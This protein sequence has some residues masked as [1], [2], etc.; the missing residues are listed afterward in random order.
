VHPFRAEGFGL[1]IV[2]AMG[3]GLPVI[4]TGYGPTLD[5]CTPETA[6]LIPARVVLLGEELPGDLATVAPPF[7]AAPNID[8]LRHYLRYVVEHRDEARA[9]GDMAR[10]WVLQHVTDG[11][12]RIEERLRELCKRPIR[13]FHRTL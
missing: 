8:L 11:A 2:E 10:S 5:Y 6:Y 13:R 12:Y 1:P 3:C 9:R 4:V 7:W